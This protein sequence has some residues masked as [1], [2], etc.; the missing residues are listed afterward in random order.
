MC[1]YAW[2][3]MEATHSFLYLFLL[4]LLSWPS[5]WRLDEHWSQSIKYLI[6]FLLEN[7]LTLILMAF[8]RP[9]A[10]MQ[11]AFTLYCHSL[12]L[13]SSTIVDS[14]QTLYRTSPCRKDLLPRTPA[15]EDW[16]LTRIT[17]RIS[18]PIANWILFAWFSLEKLF[19]KNVLNYKK[20]IIIH[21]IHVFKC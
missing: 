16:L 5:L 10:T 15:T 12:I 1:S 4:G 8:D 6:M 14:I 21:F 11:V 20:I 18:V 13:H 19:G 7:W 17:V 9:S 3:C 2:K